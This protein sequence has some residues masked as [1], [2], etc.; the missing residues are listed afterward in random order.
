MLEA[1]GEAEVKTGCTDCDLWTLGYV[2]LLDGGV[3]AGLQQPEPA[4]I[5]GQGFDYG[6][7][8]TVAVPDPRY[9]LSGTP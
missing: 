1:E 8:Y 7:I 9:F 2:D 4:K 6:V 5:V 3:N